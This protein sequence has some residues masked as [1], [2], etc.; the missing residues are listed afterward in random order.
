LK[1]L[2][3]VRE[4]AVTLHRG[5]QR[6]PAVED[7]SFDI[8]AGE[9]LGLVGESGC[10]KSLTAG[11]LFRLLPDPP[12]EVRAR[13]IRFQGHELSEAG[14]AQL[15][16]LRGDQVGM[17]FQDPATHLNPVLTVGAQIS[18]PLRFHRG[19]TKAAAREKVLELMREVGIPEPERRVD[20][21]PHELSGG[22]R[23]R[24]LIAAALACDPAL[25]I[26]DEPTTAL[27]VTL[28]AQILKLIDRER[29]QRGMGLL[30]ITHDL[31]LVAELCDRVAVMYAGRIVELGPTARIF[32]RPS[33]PY[34]AGLLAAVRALDQGR[35]DGQRLPALPGTVPAL[36][37]FEPSGCRFRER[38][39]RADLRCGELTPLLLEEQLAG[40]VGSASEVPEASARACHHPLA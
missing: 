20:A 26:A 7:V 33:H 11:S 12:V 9:T 8:A 38:C 30:F 1:E 28:Q 32:E 31:S 17:I 35:V 19:L 10:G 29:R 25:L 22:L 23:Q 40:A 6:L 5:R 37:Q 34:T 3:S 18:E 27:D 15:A 2:L 24:V 13:S 14:E 21:Y 39:E 4:L 16:A 36:E